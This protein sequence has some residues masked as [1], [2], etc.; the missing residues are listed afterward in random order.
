[1]RRYWENICNRVDTI[2]EVPAERWRIADF[3]SE[4]R[5]ARDRIYSKWGGFLE[6]VFF[7]PVKWHI[8]PASL[9]QQLPEWTEG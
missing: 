3:F 6:P 9:E 4:D 2:R 5:H 7:D 8:P 1:M